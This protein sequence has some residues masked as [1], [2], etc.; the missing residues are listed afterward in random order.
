M[1]AIGLWCW[2][3]LK[4]IQS[5]SKFPASLQTKFHHNTCWTLPILL[6]TVCCFLPG[7]L[8]RRA[9]CDDQWFQHI[10][11]TYIPCSGTHHHQFLV[12]QHNLS[13]N[14]NPHQQVFLWFHRGHMNLVYEILL[15]CGLGRKTTH[16]KQQKVESLIYG[17]SG[18]EFL[19]ET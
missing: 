13:L 7:P 2:W 12:V 17:I 1:G 4:Y 16:D 19:R 18:H 6:L 5:E 10:H 9:R 8:T 11:G 15:V 14:H 3:A